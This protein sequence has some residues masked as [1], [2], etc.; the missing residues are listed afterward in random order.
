MRLVAM[1]A[2]ADADVVIGAKDLPHASR[3]QLAKSLDVLRDGPEPVRDRLARLQFLQGVVVAEAERFDAA[4]ALEGAELER[5]Q[6]Q[7]RDACDQLLLC[8]SGDKFG[9]VAQSIRTCGL[10]I[11][12][13]EL[14]HEL[15]RSWESPLCR[16]SDGFGKVRTA[17]S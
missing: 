14:G 3:R 17:R 12:Q 10:I 15:Y 11:E 2:D 1:P 16:L 13:C 8:R 5:L 9:R 6:R 4:M 7:G